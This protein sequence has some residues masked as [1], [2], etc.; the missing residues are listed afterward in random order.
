[1]SQKI[2]LATL[3]LL[4]L[5]LFATCPTF[6]LTRKASIR[7]IQVYLPDGTMIMCV[8]TANQKTVCGSASR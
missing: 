1:M 8:K 5:T 7:D 2:A 3:R 6:S 4:A